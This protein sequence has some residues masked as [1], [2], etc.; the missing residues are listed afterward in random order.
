[1]SYLVL[2]LV[3]L[4]FH[5]C[6]HCPHINSLNHSSSNAKLSSSSSVA[7]LQSCRR[8]VAS[9]SSAA[10]LQPSSRYN[11]PSNNSRISH[12]PRL[13][14][15]QSDRS[16]NR[17]SDSYINGP[18]NDLS[19]P[20]SPGLDPWQSDG[21]IGEGKGSSSG[22]YNPKMDDGQVSQ[23][24]NGNGA[25]RIDSSGSFKRIW[26]FCWTM[27][28]KRQLRAPPRRLPHGAQWLNLPSNV[29][30]GHRGNVPP[31]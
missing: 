21:S 23:G 26:G 28:G 4:A 10:K 18:C 9:S 16:S 7:K 24:S 3:Q 11:S 2:T 6:I 27:M 31:R 5:D 14:N 22:I 20:H 12:S 15:W 13:D 17:S 19:N 8:S 25:S 30:G 1:M 29:M